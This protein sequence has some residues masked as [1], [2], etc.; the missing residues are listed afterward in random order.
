MVGEID[1]RSLRELMREPLRGGTHG[2]IS[3]RF[4]A[5]GIVETEAGRGGTK[6]ERVD[7]VLIELP[8]QDLVRAAQRLLRAGH[9]PVAA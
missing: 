2:E 6:A 9:E 8:E 3:E 5:L 7:S 1:L 4:A